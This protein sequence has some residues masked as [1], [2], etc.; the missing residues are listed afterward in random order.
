MMMI[1]NDLIVTLA[2]KLFEVLEKFDYFYVEIKG[3]DGTWRL[4]R[5]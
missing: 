2:Y 1:M 4:V 5:I 3:F